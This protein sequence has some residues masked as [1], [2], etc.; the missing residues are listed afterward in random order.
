MEIDMVIPARLLFLA[1]G[2]VILL[3]ACVTPRFETV[4]RLEPPEHAAGRV[5]LV[6]CEDRLKACQA[7]CGRSYQTCLEAIGPLVDEAYAEALRHYAFD[8]DSYAA[9][10]QHYEMQLWMG[11][12]HGP[13]WFSPGWSY[14]YYV[15]RPPPRPTRTQIR[16]RLIAEKCDKDCGCQPVYEACFLACGGRKVGEERCIANCPAP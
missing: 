6:Q 9:S 11:W 14:P 1:A 4:Y 10:L 16:E 7:D 5:C 2:A 8:L 13:W 3:G 12:H 15:S